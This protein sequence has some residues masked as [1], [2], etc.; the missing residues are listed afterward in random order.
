M[1]KTTLTAAQVLF[2][3]VQLL[4]LGTNAPT[5]KKENKTN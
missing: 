2:T 1:T 4:L 5:Q 3:Y